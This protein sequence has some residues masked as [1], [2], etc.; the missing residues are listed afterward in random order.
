MVLHDAL[1]RD[2]AVSSEDS[3]QLCEIYEAV[4]SHHAFTGR[5]GSMYK[6]EG[7]GCIYW[8]MVSKLAL[9]TSETADRARAAGASQEVLA[10]LAERFRDIKDGIGVHKTPAQYGAFPTDPYSH[11]PGFI[12]VQQP[13]SQPLQC[14]GDRT[15][16]ARY[17]ADCADKDHLS[18]DY[19]PEITKLF[20]VD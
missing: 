8:H 17:A 14:L 6:Y 9:S 19:L 16:A 2:P 15:F 7:L 4:F 3:R 5:S 20:P 13:G 11:T 12:G 1:E 10:S 18:I